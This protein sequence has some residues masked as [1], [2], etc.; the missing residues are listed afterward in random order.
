[1]AEDQ[2]DLSDFEKLAEQAKDD[3]TYDTDADDE[4]EKLEG[5]IERERSS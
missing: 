4:S 3:N 2:S 1:M 5:S